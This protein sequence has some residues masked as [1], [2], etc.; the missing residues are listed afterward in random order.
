[1]V[2]DDGKHISSLTEKLY[3]TLRTGKPQIKTAKLIYEAF[4]S[5]SEWPDDEAINTA[6]R[7]LILRDDIVTYG[8][9]ENWRHSEI[10]KI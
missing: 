6:L 9:I 4:S 1:M 5:H 7:K 2:S 10:K 3:N 8:L